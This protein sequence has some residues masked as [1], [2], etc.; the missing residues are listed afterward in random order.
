MERHSKLVVI[1]VFGGG[2]VSNGSRLGGNI[3]PLSPEYRIPVHLE[4]P[5]TGY[6]SGGRVMDGNTGVTAV[7]ETVGY[8]LRGLEDDGGRNGGVGGGA[9]G[10]GVEMSNKAGY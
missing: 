10:A 2:D 5:N 7:V 9:G 4:P 1:P 6:F 8:L 3:S